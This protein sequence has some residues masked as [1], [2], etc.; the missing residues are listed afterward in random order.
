LNSVSPDIL[1]VYVN[2]IDNAFINMMTNKNIKISVYNEPWKLT[3]KELANNA[4]VSGFL[5]GLVF[6]M[7]MTFIP[8]SIIVFIVKERLTNVKHQHCVSGV[9]LLAYYGANYCVDMIKYLIPAI[10]ACIM[11]EAFSIDIYTSSSSTYGA[12]WLIY[13]L[14]GFNM[15]AFVNIF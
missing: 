7:G 11:V 12:V 10:F 4:T 9:S 3:Q 14:Y 13:I 2:A 1:P 8:A 15:L 5:A 6:V